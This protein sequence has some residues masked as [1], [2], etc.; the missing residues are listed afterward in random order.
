MVNILVFEENS[1]ISYTCKVIFTHIFQIP[2][3]IYNQ[4][5]APK[6]T[7]FFTINYTP[8]PIENSLQIP[9]IGLLSEKIIQSCRIKDIN[10]LIYAANIAEKNYSPT[11]KIISYDVF[12]IIF[13]LTS[14]YEKY[15]ISEK[16]KYDRY[17]ETRYPS[18]SWGIRQEPLVHQFCENLL[19]TFPPILQNEI[20]SKRKFDYELTWDI[21]HPWKYLYKGKLRFYLGFLRDIWK[22]NKSNLRERVQ[23]LFS[24]K[25]DPNDTYPIIK[26]ISPP[27]K[28]TF[29]F[30]IGTDT[31]HDSLFGKDNSHFQSLI[32]SIQKEGYAIGIHP[33][34]NTYLDAAKIENE[35]KTLS[36]IIQQP[37]IASRQHFLRYRFPDTFQ[38]LISAGIKKEYSLCLVNDLGFPCGMA[39]PFPWYDLTKEEITDLIIYPAMV[40]DRSLESYIK[41]SK[42]EKMQKF[43]SILG[44]VKHFGGK[45]I[46]ILHNDSLSE[47]REWQGWSE[48]IK[49]MIGE[50]VGG[51]FDSA[52]FDSAQCKQ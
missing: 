18:F 6:D 23:I 51:H 52:H 38:H 17:E 27:E 22:G 5:Q 4:S 50:I 30:L 29:F 28:T 48:I 3:K 26:A 25:K 11:T 32:Q 19:A 31:V 43:R 49:E 8:L 1:R 44:Q 9:P 2:Y 10:E 20:V 33:S 35:T 16:D 21:D 14:N 42:E 15:V 46:F 34:F 45:F 36:E 12:S 40:M 47:S 24:G 7:S 37:I 13:F 41:G 39:T